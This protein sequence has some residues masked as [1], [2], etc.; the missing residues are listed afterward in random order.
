MSVEDSQLSYFP[1]GI[2]RGAALLGVLPSSSRP[3][4]MEPTWVD[5]RAF[6]A[7]MSSADLQHLPALLPLRRGDLDDFISTLSTMTVNNL[8]LNAKCETS[9]SK[10][11]RGDA[12]RLELLWIYICLTVSRLQ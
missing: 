4:D 10:P 11:E 12:G 6:R 9:L 8:F 3:G 7:M 1:A 2:P 5:H